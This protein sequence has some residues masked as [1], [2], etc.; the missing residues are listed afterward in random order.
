M[1]VDDHETIEFLTD[2]EREDRRKMEIR[3]TKRRRK[4]R[5]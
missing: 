1:K 5:K 3:E 2:D 4:K